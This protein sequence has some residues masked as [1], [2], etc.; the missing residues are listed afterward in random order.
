MT[1]AVSDKDMGYR[2]LMKRLGGMHSTQVLVGVRSTGHEL[3]ISDEGISGESLDLAA[4]AEV[5]EFGSSD[6]HVPERSFLRS[7]I[8]QHRVQYGLLLE[9]AVERMI[10]GAAPEVAYGRVGLAAVADV[11]RTIR[12]R[13]PPPNAPST[14]KRKGSDVPLIDTGRLIQSIDYTIEAWR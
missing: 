8:D 7:T 5:N 2:D 12:S 3:V 4:I 10:D 1:A 11:Q 9:Q 14:I 13:V 6:G